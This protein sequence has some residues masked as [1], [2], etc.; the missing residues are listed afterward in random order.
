VVDG[1]FAVASLHLSY[2]KRGE[3]EKAFYFNVAIDQLN[4]GLVQYRKELLNVTESS[5]EALFS[6]ATIMSSWVVATVGEEC[7]TIIHPLKNGEVSAPQ[8]EAATADLAFATARIF[9]CLRG[10]LL[11]LTPFWNLIVKG[12]FGPIT[13]KDWPH[14]LPASPTAAEVDRKL[15]ALEEIWMKPESKYE[16]YFDTLAATLKSLRES[17]ALIS[18]LSIP[19][20]SELYGCQDLELP[21]WTSVMAWIIHAPIEFIVL[22]EKRVLEAWVILSHCAIL[23]SKVK[24]V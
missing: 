7:K 23:P 20:S 16:Y 21:D 14:P 24:G 1:V 2:V 17:F 9:R 5:A 8:R 6:F 12:I 11:I 13:Q 18:Q 10:V 3:A 4:K 15:H 19:A 22:L